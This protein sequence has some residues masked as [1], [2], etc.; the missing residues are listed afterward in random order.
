MLTGG[1]LRTRQGDQVKCG[2]GAKLNLA[3]SSDTNHGG[4]KWTRFW[5]PAGKLERGRL[6]CETARM[7]TKTRGN[8]EAAR[9]A[10]MLR[11]VK[12]KIWSR[13]EARVAHD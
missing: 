2:K 12:K 10:G 5:G 6:G 9:Y 4:L 7:T 8:S 3:K 1:R 11:L 13:A